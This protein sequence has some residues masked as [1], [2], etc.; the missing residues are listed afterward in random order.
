[1]NIEDDISSNNNNI[2]NS[3]HNLSETEV[4]AEV[5]DRQVRLWG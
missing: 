1:M 4:E 3:N 5:Y 2:I